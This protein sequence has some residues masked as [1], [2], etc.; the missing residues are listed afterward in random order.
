M[1]RAL[2]EISPLLA[3]VY[4]YVLM[5]AM[6][7]A[8]VV[9]D[10]FVAPSIH[11]QSL[12]RVPLMTVIYI[13]FLAYFARISAPFATAPLWARSLRILTELMLLYTLSSNCLPLMDQMVK[14]NQWPLADPWL[15]KAD[16]MIGFDWLA[17]FNFVHDTPWLFMVFDHA[18]AQTGILS[19]LVVLSLILLGQFRRIQFHMEAVVWT[20]V[21]CTLISAIT[22]AYAAAIYYGI[23]FADYPNFGFAPGIYHIENLLALR[24]ASPDYRIG[25]EPFKGLITFPSVHTA[26]GVIMAGALWR[27]WLFWPIALYCAVMIPSTPVLGSHYIIDVIAGAGLSVVVML[28]VARRQRYAGVF[29]SSPR[30]D[31]SGVPAE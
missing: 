30:S 23:D 24:E 17:Y 21:I 25:E 28:V 2:D 31:V 11:W 4:I 3:P 8:A 14:I 26:L 5:M 9:I 22:P 1:T 10:W 7:P 15:A 27:H 6:L 29:R 12:Y 19:F 16:A 18:Y 20:V 13:G